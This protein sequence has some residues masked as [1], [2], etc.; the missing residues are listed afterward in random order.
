VV[1]DIV[2]EVVVVVE[3]VGIVVVVGE[4]DG[5]DYW[6]VW[7]GCCELGSCSSFLHQIDPFFDQ[8]VFLGFRVW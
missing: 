3:T 2:A 5:L 7:L 8:L 1:V 6:K 4:K